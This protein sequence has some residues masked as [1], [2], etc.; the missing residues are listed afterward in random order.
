MPVS[1]VATHG[2][3]LSLLVEGP[4]P[5]PGPKSGRRSWQASMA[6]WNSSLCGSMP[7]GPRHRGLLATDL[8]ADAAVGLRVRHVDAVVAHALG[9][10]DHL[11]EL[12]LR[13]LARPAEA[14]VLEDVL[15]GLL[16]RLELLATGIDAVL[17]DADPD[18]AAPPGLRVGHVDAVVAHALG[19]LEHGVLG[20][21][22]GVGRG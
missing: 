3:G 21:R 2:A 20:V 18:A 13:E 14:G 5:L 1:G 9:E 17:P 11:V 6:A 19:E 12:L 10:L 4:S 16:G 22:G 7:P 8:D 15:A